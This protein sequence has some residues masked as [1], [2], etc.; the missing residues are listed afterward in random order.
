MHGPLGANALQARVRIPMPVQQPLAM[1]ISACV[2]TCATGGKRSAPPLPLCQAQRR[3]ER[4]QRRRAAFVVADVL[5]L[6]A[7]ESELDTSV[8]MV[9]LI[10]DDDGTA[11][12]HRSRGRPSIRCIEA[13]RDA[14]RDFG[15]ECRESVN[16]SAATLAIVPAIPGQVRGTVAKWRSIFI[17]SIVSSSRC[18]EISPAIPK[19]RRRSVLVE[20]VLAL[21]DM[22]PTSRDKDVQTLRDRIVTGRPLPAGTWQA[23]AEE[24]NIPT[25]VVKSTLRRSANA[26][27]VLD[28]LIREKLEGTITRRAPGADMLDYVDAE[29]YDATPMKT[30]VMN[31]STTAV[32]YLAMPDELNSGAASPN[33]RN[34]TS[35]AALSLLRFKAD[36]MT[37]KLRQYQIMWGCLVEVRLECLGIVGTTV[38][39]VDS[40]DGTSNRAMLPAISAHSGVTKHASKY[41][42]R[43]SLACGDGAKSLPTVE[44]TFMARR[45]D[46]WKRVMSLC[47]LHISFG[48]ISRAVQA[49]RE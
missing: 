20:N 48:V 44:R 35:H 26:T 14:E 34:G 16:S 23:F 25:D 15:D 30:T 49:L 19:P 28:R 22:R 6:A 32:E 39:G 27:F 4:L 36:A 21:A 45:G 42:R 5:M 37:T 18:E 33:S 17:T 13:V 41:K 10:A 7:T 11:G 1:V 8:P 24:L 29:R 38:A 9:P 47:E 46:S 31:G 43:S 40:L 2:A 12:Y 3:W